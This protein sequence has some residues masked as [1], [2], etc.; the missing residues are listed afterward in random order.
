MELFSGIVI[1]LVVVIGYMVISKLDELLD[2]LGVLD[3][4]L[5]ATLKET[6]IE[7][8]YYKRKLTEKKEMIEAWGDFINPTEKGLDEETQETKVT[9]TS[10]SPESPNPEGVFDSLFY[11]SK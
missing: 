3:K 5:G 11:W 4:E 2:E 8:D 10:K 6:K 7:R 1:F 9:E